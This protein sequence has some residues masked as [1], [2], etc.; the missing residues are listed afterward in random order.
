MNDTS[1]L[2][3]DKGNPTSCSRIRGELFLSPESMWIIHTK[4]FVKS[5]DKVAKEK[6]RNPN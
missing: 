4:Y 5:F 1:S 3:S 2:E 6:E